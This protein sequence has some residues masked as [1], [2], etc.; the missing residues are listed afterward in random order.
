MNITFSHS[1]I[2]TDREAPEHGPSQLPVSLFT[3]TYY[4]LLPTIRF[5][6]FAHDL[7]ST[8]QKYRANFHFETKLLFAQTI[9][10]QKLRS[11]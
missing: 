7:R 6:L 2:C 9:S 8:F 1:Y 3:I 10:F 5:V 4:S 11:A